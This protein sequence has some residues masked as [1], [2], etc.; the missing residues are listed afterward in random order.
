MRRSRQKRACKGQKTRIQTSVT[1]STNTETWTTHSGAQALQCKLFTAK[2]NTVVCSIMHEPTHLVVIEDL[3]RFFGAQE[4]NSAELACGHVFHPVALALHFLVSDMRCPVCRCGFTECMGIQNIPAEHRSC[5]ASKMQ[6]IKDAEM[7]AENDIQMSMQ[8]RVVELVNNLEL[9]LHV[10][11]PTQQL[12]P[13]RTRVL[14]TLTQMQQMQD[15][16]VLAGSNPALLWANFAVHWSFQRL[17]VALVNSQ[18]SKNPEHSVHFVLQHPLVPVAMVSN[19]MRMSA[20]SENLFEHC[21]PHQNSQVPLYC[22]HI[23]GS[24]PVAYLR[25]NFLHDCPVPNISMDVNV[26]F[27][28]NIARYV[29]D[30]LQSIQEAVEQHTSVFDSPDPLEVTEHAANGIQM[31]LT[32]MQESEVLVHVMMMILLYHHHHNMHHC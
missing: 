19:K 23:T 5:F 16:L 25:V 20:A 32:A 30:V 29:S 22:E 14:T 24:E 4:V 11:P 21:A 31:D 1:D 27:L 7:A 26:F 17:M 15:N 8:T 6:R 13:I 3:P 9:Q 2:D 18:A 12:T 10:H 28:T